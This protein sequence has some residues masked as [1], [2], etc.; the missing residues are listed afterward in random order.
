MYIK[1]NWLWLLGIHNG[2]YNLA[3]ETHVDLTNK[4][5]RKVLKAR[6]GVQN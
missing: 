2:V 6:R 5:G 1:M 3:K 4:I